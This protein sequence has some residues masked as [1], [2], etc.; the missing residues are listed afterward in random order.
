VPIYSGDGWL[1]H[2]FLGGFSLICVGEKML[3][4]EESRRESLFL[5]FFHPRFELG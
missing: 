1:L 2:P 4:L 3:G 5:A